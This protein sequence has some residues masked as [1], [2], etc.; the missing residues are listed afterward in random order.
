MRYAQTAVRFGRL[1][2]LTIALFI[3]AT[4]FIWTETAGAVD[5]PVG[6][7]QATVETTPVSHTGDAADDPAI[8][9]DP[10]D[11]SRSIVIGNDKGGAL[12]VYDLS[13]ARI[14][15]LT[16]GF[17]GNVDVR[18]GFVT[19]TGIIDIAITYHAGGARV[20]RIDPVTRLLSNVTDAATG[21]IPSPIG[22]EG[23]CIYHSTQT[24]QFS[25]FVNARTGRIGQWVLGDADG[26]G[27]IEGSL[28]RQW[29]VGTEV[30]GCVA[31][32]ELGDL[33]ISEENVAI[34]KYG[35][36][37]SD[38]TNTA[39]RVAVDRTIAAGGHIRPDA[40]GLTIVYQPG[41]TGY[42]IAS[43]QA[44]SDT[45]NS[46]L[47]YERQGANPFIRSFRV[48]D[49]TTVD[50]C[51]R[52]DGIDALAADLGPAFP[53]G[54]F[55]C[56]DNHNT[57]PGNSGN[58]NF[59]FVPL[60]R[61]VGLSDEPPP[62]QPP[63]AVISVQCNG[64]A[65]S[66]SGAGSSDQDG[67]IDS[68]AWDFGDG[69]TESGVGAPHTYDAAGTYTIT[70]TVTDDDGAP[71]VASEPVTVTEETGAI[72]FVG[73]ASSNA[74]N[75]IHRVTVPAAVVA[76]DGLL[77]FMATNTSATISEPSG[78]AGWQPLDT[79]SKPG[80][81]VRVWR[82]VAQASDAGDTVRV[83]VS[84]TSKANLVVMAYRGTSALDP[85]AAFASAI[86]VAGRS[87]HVTPIVDVALTGSWVVSYW[88]HKD[89]TATLLSPPEGVTV[90]ANSTQSGSGT[91]KGLIVDTGGPVAA[92]PYGGLIAV[93]GATASNATMW[94][95]VLALGS[96]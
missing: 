19:G 48:T 51:A 12:E 68:Y 96:G 62:N 88:T 94:T 11:P 9:R 3:V 79:L 85:V 54:I 18:T 65:C 20:F 28:A 86:D 70:L 42:L 8:W 31:D 29:D 87:S 37:P 30:E 74:N 63:N 53:N 24:G 77:L 25:V 91:V 34:W 44:A 38:P 67:T 39:S 93:A 27:L 23:I 61:V 82:K 15:R 2:I 43:S 78:V 16:G 50:G 66:M 69:T 1:T 83:D 26:D 5:Q 40:E 47:V 14:Q 59:K 21:S 49:G 58:Q 76:G 45:L 57:L 89:S 7:A 6:D 13:G 64:L 36:E 4:S 22:G 80:S 32:D 81:T 60:E 71:D 90:R 10:S 84:A 73:Q 56:Q 55:V 92:G 75:T 52:T 35:A 41:G 33:Y 46:Y 72:S 17:Y 95:I